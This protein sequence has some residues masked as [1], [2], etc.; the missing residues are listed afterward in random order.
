M[1]QIDLKRVRL[2]EGMFCRS[3]QTGKQYLLALEPDRLLAPCIE[4]AGEQPK[5]ERYGGW[6]QREIAGHSLG[7]WLSAASY[8]YSATG[9]EMLLEKIRYTVNELARMQDDK[10]Y[11]G[12]VKRSVFDALADGDFTAERFSLNGVWVPWYS[13]HKLYQGLIDAYVQAKVTCAL[14][15]VTR[16]TDWAVSLIAHLSDEQ[17]TKMMFCEHGGMNDVFAQMYEITGDAAYLTA[18]KRFTDASV[19]KPL[20]GCRDELEGLHANTQLPKIIGAE[21]I[22]TAEYFRAA[23]FFFDTVTAHRSYV[24]GGNSESENFEKLNKETLGVQTCETCNTYNMIKLAEQLFDKEHDS[25]YMDYCEA[26]LYNHILASQDPDSG[27]KTYFVSTEPGHFKVYCTPYDSFWC[28]TG[29]GMENPARYGRNIYYEDGDT[30]YVNLFI[31]STLEYRGIKL[32]QTTT[33]PKDMTSKLIIEDGEGEFT[34]K[35]RVPA[36]NKDMTV[37]VNGQQIQSV[38]E[39][40]YFTVKR[41]FRKGDVIDIRLSAAIS[42]RQKKDDPHCISFLYGPIA[43]AA[44]LGTENF[45]ETDIQADHVA[46]NAHTRIDVAPI[47]TEKTDLS[48]LVSPM[49]NGTL[50]FAL[51]LGGGRQYILRPFYDVHH[52][53]YS[54][55]FHVYTPQEYEEVQK[56]QITEQNRRVIDCV[57]P[58]QQQSEVDHS[59]R[60]QNMQANYL[61][62]AGCGYRFAY[63][64]DGWFEYTLKLSGAKELLVTYWG[65]D[66]DFGLYADTYRREFDILCD[67]E[68]LGQCSLHK[69]KEGELFTVSYPILG[70]DKAVI[71]FQT[72]GAKTCAGGV[73]RIEAV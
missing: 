38:A 16:L 69:E 44:E 70:K 1:G 27:M 59:L 22:G 25:R 40:G 20:C 5:A 57:Y 39:K 21:R 42:V 29:T 66:D 24:I 10:G 48:E 2:T 28:C 4:A 6:E 7:H 64:E 31:A 18:A 3:Q 51:D 47:M 55:Y 61:S 60:G 52:Q 8:M 34:L 23:R 14:E 37:S 33:F 68:L 49:D 73:F 63:G 12:G 15:V 35:I 58:S 9:D 56:R 45:P 17:M 65:S 11:V 26:A 54:L 71:R 19:L 41:Y 67:G 13:L 62:A 43:L 36:W 72:H 30:L 32:S 50:T 46:L 53:R